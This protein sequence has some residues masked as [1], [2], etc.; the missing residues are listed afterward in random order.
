[1]TGTT[2]DWRNDLERWLKPFLDLLGNKR[3]R[4][5]CPVY[6]TG[7]IGPG[8]RKSIQPMA[9]RTAPGSYD[10]LHHFVSAGVWEPAAVETELLVQA[11][12]LVGGRDAVLVIDDTTILKKGRHSVGVAPQYCSTLGKIANCQT[13]VS[14]TLARGEVPVMA[15]L[16]LFLPES[17]TL[18]R[19]RLKR[20]GVPV[21]Y[22]KPRTKP[23]IALAEIDRVIAAGV[24]FGCVL[25]D[26]GYG[27]YVQFR[28]G[29]TARKLT[30][31]VGIPRQL[32]FYPAGVKMIWPVAR[33]GPPRQYSL[34][35]TPAAAAEDMLAQAT[36]QTISWR[37]GTK[38]KLKARFAAV[39][40]RVADGPRRGI[41]GKTRQGVPGGQ[42]WLV[43]EHRTSGEKK[44]Y[45]ANL[46]EN[47]SLRTLAQ[48]IKGRW[49]CEQAHQQ[50]KE[51]LG[52]D[53]FEGRSWQGLHRHALMTMIAY[54]FLQFRRLAAA[55][56]K[57]KNQRST[58]PAK[59]A[60]RTARYSRALRSTTATAVSSLPKLAIQSAAA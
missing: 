37:T 55:K 35:D 3:R 49:I 24:R 2:L 39:R 17:W 48:T 20:A 22:R 42:V 10:Q 6:V 16:R 5:M 14:L 18:D 36:W 33:R 11:D 54:A 1:M 29:L 38:G 23:E 9:E 60:R 52:L 26:A 21:E 8:D 53:H 4:R 31:A 27:P 43:G 32:R 51:E 7:L 12:K 56:R 34:P 46:P 59:L 45:L 15:S 19:S 58:A 25:A 30:W 57:K 44:Y 28:N 13:L 47:T 41:R 50:L 40:V